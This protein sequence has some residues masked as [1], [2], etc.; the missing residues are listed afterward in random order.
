MTILLDLIALIVLLLFLFY[1]VL[2]FYQWDV[3][4]M[5]GVGS[6]QPILRSPRRPPHMLAVASY[7]FH[8]VKR[9]RS[10]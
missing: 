3:Y 5:F 7:G 4:A 2:F 6:V 10:S 9:N 8:V 1:L